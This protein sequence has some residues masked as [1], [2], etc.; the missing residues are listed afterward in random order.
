MERYSK[1]AGYER[2]TIGVS[3]KET[4]NLS[5]CLHWGYDT[6]VKSGI[7]ENAE[8]GLVLYYSKEL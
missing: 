8:E 6:F 1:N 2:A 5:I 7:S 3:A 4:R